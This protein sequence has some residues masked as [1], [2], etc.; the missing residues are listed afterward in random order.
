MLASVD[1]R[2]F[3]GLAP[4][5]TSRLFGRA[6][7]SAIWV[8]T[9]LLFAVSP[10]LAPGSLSESSLLTVLSF[11]SILAVAA[12]GQ[13]LVLQQG[14]LDLTVPGAISVAAV[15]VTDYPNG[16]DAALLEWLPVAILSGAASGLLCGIVIVRFRLTPMVATLGVNALLYGLVLYITNGSSTRAVP[17]ALGNFTVGRILSAPNLAVLAVVIIIAVECV[18]RWSVVGRRFVAVGD[19]SRAAT[20]SGLRVDAYKVAAYII[21][22]VAYAI[23]GILLAG[24]LGIPSLLVGDTYLLPSVAAAVL[25]GTSLLGGSGSVLATAIGALFLTQLQQI[26]LGMGA[27]AAVQDITEAVIIALGM[28]I[29]LVPWRSGLKSLLQL[30]SSI[31]R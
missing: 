18:V 22:G 31:R 7:Y 9:L 30:G 14:G 13:T 28:T 25:G 2:R 27:S 26:A 6:Q 11:G 17:A 12:M 8:A 15:L 19:S 21:A 10:V 3:V 1:K 4:S 23:A 24:Y 20:A 29:R 16:N 5:L